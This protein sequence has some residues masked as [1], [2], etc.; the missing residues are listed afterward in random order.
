MLNHI[1]NLYAVR[2]ILNQNKMVICPAYNEWSV[3]CD[4]LMVEK[5]EA[6]NQKGPCILDF[7]IVLLVNN[8][9]QL[10][11]FIKSVHPRIETL[12]LYHDRPVNVIYKAKK[13]VPLHLC[14]KENKIL[15]RI[16]KNENLRDLIAMR[17]RPL[18]CYP[19]HNIKNNK[20]E[21]YSE[22]PRY[23]R[24]RLDYIFPEF[25]SRDWSASPPQ[26]L[27]F[28]KKGDLFFHVE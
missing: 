9:V 8:F 5:F 4:P 26:T 28:N 21:P 1:D 11:H 3:I 13:W 14:N 10:K 6:F 19:V 16:T 7:P 24:S 12:L 15:I 22:I 23:W 27:S 17:K 25:N 2:D 20:S 18:G